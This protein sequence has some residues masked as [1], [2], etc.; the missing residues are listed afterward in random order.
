MMRRGTD[1]ITKLYLDSRTALPDGSI[2]LPRDIQLDPS[3][4]VW[5]AEFSTVASWDTIDDS[6][7]SIFITERVNGVDRDRIVTIPNGP[8]T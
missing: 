6:N 7:N 8:T 1:R 3:T 4:R 5:L 2:Q